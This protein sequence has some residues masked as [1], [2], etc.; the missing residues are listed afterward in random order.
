MKPDVLSEKQRKPYHFKDAYTI[1]NEGI[2]INE[3]I[4]DIPKLLQAQLDDTWQKAQDNYEPLIQQAKAEV[5]REIL[6][7]MMCVR[8]EGHFGEPYDMWELKPSDYQDFKSKYPQGEKDG[9]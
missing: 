6:S 1:G 5:A 4:W 7:K 8:H 3:E 9:K 2:T